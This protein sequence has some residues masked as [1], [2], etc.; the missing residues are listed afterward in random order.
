MLLCSGCGQLVCVVVTIE[1]RR[2]GVSV[3]EGC[4]AKAWE[5]LEGHTGCA[6]ADDGAGVDELG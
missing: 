1:D 6:D 4:L 3:C 2:G 5:E